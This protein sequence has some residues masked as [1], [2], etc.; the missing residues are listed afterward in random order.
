MAEQ[1]QPRA[2]KQDQQFTIAVIPDT[3]NYLDYTHQKAEG[4]PFDASAMFIEQMQYIAD[5]LQSAGGHIAFVSSLGD[6][7]QHQSKSMD[8]RH[9]ERG[10]KR[11]PNPLLD[12][13]F[14]PT[15]QVHLFEMPKAHEGYSLIAGKVPFSV[16][17][18][19]HDHD[20]MWTDSKFPAAKQF[21]PKDLTTLGVLHPGGLDNFR[22]VFG[23][24]TE[25]FKDKPWYVSSHDG[26]ADSAQV[27]SAGGYRFLHIGLRFDPPDETLAW[28][29]AVIKR[30]P[31]LPTI[32]S[33]HNYLNTDGRRLSNAI[34]DGHRVDPV[35]N[36]PEMVWEK[37]ISKND[38][39]FLVLCG[40]QHGQATRMDDNDFGNPVWQ[41]LSDYQ[42]RNQT[43]RDAGIEMKG[44]PIQIGDGWMRL[45]TFDFRGEVPTIKVRTYSTHYQV[46]SAK[47]PEYADW[48]KH[49]EQPYMSDDQFI[50]TDHFNVK[51]V[52][53]RQRFAAAE[54]LADAG[55]N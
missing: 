40:H 1:S 19:N 23:A 16:V 33:T 18:G 15:E 39:I 35:H 55:R 17:P 9:V 54:R 5:N 21:N 42:G 41:L 52:D 44:W 27:F 24:D 20:A 10:F 36:N 2:E 13:H 43:A 47:H 8:P 38:Q 50:G 7:W 51:L 28:A 6:V 46:E 4:F 49:Q 45:L 53:F 25:F 30:F 34:I 29:A 31:G 11:V 14:A 48:Y 12:A 22:S 32:V 3:Q 37:F 26:G